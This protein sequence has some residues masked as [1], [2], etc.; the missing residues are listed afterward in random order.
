MS[1]GGLGGT[2]DRWRSRFVHQVLAPQSNSGGM[3]VPRKPA[4]A[5]GAKDG[6]TVDHSLR[7]AASSMS[8][9]DSGESVLHHAGR[10]VRKSFDR[11]DML[12]D[13]LEG[14]ELAGAGTLTDAG[15]RRCR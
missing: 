1:R 6:G 10:G 13:E 7:S 11:S 8:I 3:A 5:S 4:C 12:R 15:A 14:M 2:K 9:P